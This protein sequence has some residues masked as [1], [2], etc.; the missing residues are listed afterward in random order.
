ME[1]RDVNWTP[2]LS[3]MST[4]VITHLNTRASQESPARGLQY[5]KHSP[6]SPANAGP[7]AQSH[8]PL[9]AGQKHPLKVQ[10]RLHSLGLLIRIPLAPYLAIT[11]HLRVR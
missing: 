9:V 3:V 8:Y 4:P 7:S 5:F 10:L 6:S 2:I 1:S 11:G